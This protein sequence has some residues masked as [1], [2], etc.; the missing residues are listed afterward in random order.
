MRET[1]G[2]DRRRV[3]L[4]AAAVAFG[5]AFLLLVF[6]RGGGRG[7]R[8]RG[9]PS[10]EVE[11]ESEPPAGTSAER[12]AGQ[13]G[14]GRPAAG[15]TDAP[16]DFEVVVLGPDEVPLSAVAIVLPT[17]GR[18]STDEEGSAR[19]EAGQ[20]ERMVVELSVHGRFLDRPEIAR[21][22]NLL[23]YPDLPVLEVELV[24]ATTGAPVTDAR[25][26]L[27]GR[28]SAVP[29]FLE[30]SLFVHGPLPRPPGGD[31]ELEFEI[32][33]PRGYAVYPPHRLVSGPLSRF[34][35]KL[36][37]RIPLWPEAP[38]AVLVLHASG[39]PAGGASVGPVR[40]GGTRLPGVRG[41]TDGSGTAL[42]AGVPRL[43]GEEVVVTASLGLLRARSTPRRIG[44]GGAELSARIVLSREGGEVYEE[45]EDL[46]FEESIRDSTVRD[47]HEV[48]EEHP[49]GGLEVQVVRWDGSPGGGA[50]VAVEV[51]RRWL[52][53]ARADTGGVARFDDLPAGM[54][55]IDVR[56]PGF[57]MG[58]REST[59]VLAGE[60]YRRQVSEAAGRSSDVLVRHRGGGLVP[61]AAVTVTLPGGRRWAYVDG[62]CQH[63]RVYTDE[64]GRA[65]LRRLPPCAVGVRAHFGTRRV[66]GPAP[67]GRN[68]VLFLPDR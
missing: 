51:D 62:D 50:E 60:T 12:A 46:G 9:V 39:E 11:P 44:E 29:L 38:L 22:R 10:A 66:S 4:L 21:G 61:H 64:T 17:G 40:I 47:H 67:P 7:D 54:A 8:E 33:P 59:V 2:R 30:S 32:D 26:R 35:R 65:V 23:R 1:A 42:L 28:T 34:A 52:A 45:G 41:T 37:V 20:A 57:L 58:E 49:R 6:P 15:E 55:R 53:T 3:L 36:R 25:V 31:V 18:L 16:R 24:D 43:P 14:T 13:A 63:L 48:P 5:A 19:F 68:P 27:V 56:D